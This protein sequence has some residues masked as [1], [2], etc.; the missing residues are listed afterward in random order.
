MAHR[1][2]DPLTKR[3]ILRTFELLRLFAPFPRFVAPS[4]WSCST[5]IPTW[6]TSRSV[7][8]SHLTN[9][10]SWCHWFVMHSTCVH[11]NSA[12]AQGTI[13]VHLYGT[14]GASTSGASRTGIIGDPCNPPPSALMS[15]PQQERNIIKT[16][17]F[18]CFIGWIFYLVPCA[19]SPFHIS[20]F[21]WFL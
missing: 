6:S 7:S 12:E 10:H 4:V 19:Y 21:V 3:H 18:Y 17:I 20:P 2:T 8:T 16:G 11:T 9:A 14:N 15:N 1:Y 5:L 13:T